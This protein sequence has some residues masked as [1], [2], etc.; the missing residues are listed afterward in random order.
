MAN[1]SPKRRRRASWLVLGLLALGALVV[2]DAVVA[3][4][5][6]RWALSQLRGTADAAVALRGA[7]LRS[8]IEKQRALPLVLAGDPGV[9]EALAAPQ[10]GRLLPLDER[11][12]R[13]AQESRAGAIYV[14]DA[15]GLTRAASNFRTAESF[16]GSNYAFRPYF[17]GAM[18]LEVYRIGKV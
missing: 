5:A 11:L 14:I 2:L 1:L 13:I 3:H 15:N 17:T 12:E 6:E 18:T 8:E 9:Q 16:V 7:M 10:E 4:V